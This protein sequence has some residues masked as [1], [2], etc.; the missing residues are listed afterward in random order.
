[1]K[2]MVAGEKPSC[3]PRNAISV[4][5]RPLP[6]SRMPAAMRSGING[7]IEDIC[8][9]R[10]RLGGLL[11]GHCAGDFQHNTASDL[12]ETAFALTNQGAHALFR[13]NFGPAVCRHFW[14]PDQDMTTHRYR[15]HTCAQLRKSDAGETVRL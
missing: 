12:R 1:M 6:P 8:D 2:P 5:C 10:I 9:G 3:A 15:S 14:Y 7:R 11:L 13:A 4:P